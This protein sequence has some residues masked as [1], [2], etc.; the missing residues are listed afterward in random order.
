[1]DFVDRTLVRL[2]QPATAASV[3]DSAALKSAVNAAYDASR[4]GVEGPFQPVFDELGLGMTAPR[5]A[6][7]QGTWNP[8]GGVERTEA[9]FTMTGVGAD[10]PVRID[11]LWRGAVVA[12]VVRPRD[13]IAAV[14]TTWPALGSIDEDIEANLGSL[15]S[16]PEALEDERRERLLERLRA[17][18]DQPGALTEARLTEVLASVEA[19]SVSDLLDRARGVAQAGG[20]TVTF[21]PAPAST[22]SP[23]ALPL[24]VAVLVRPAPLAVAQLLSDTRLVRD[25]LEPLSVAPAADPALGRRRGLIAA[26]VVPAEVFDDADWPGATSGMTVAQR[27]TARRTAAAAWL[28]REGIALAVPP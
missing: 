11:A 27:R 8:V 5:V 10:A 19:D 1:V 2:A 23:L 3:F 25:R 12:R 9:S 17:G 18:L 16:D 14:D 26:W 13:Q 24:A 20:V 6:T 7:A 22:P 28:A 15:P 21:S 4:L